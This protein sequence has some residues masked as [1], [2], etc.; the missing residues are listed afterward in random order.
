MRRKSFFPALCLLA[1][2]TAC[3]LLVM[4]QC[5]PATLAAPQPPT[6]QSSAQTSDFSMALDTPGKFCVLAQRADGLW[7]CRTAPLDD[8]AQNMLTAYGITLPATLGTYQL[9]AVHDLELYLGDTLWLDDGV[10]LLS[11]G[12]EAGQIYDWTDRLTVGSFSAD[13][14][15]PA[16]NPEHHKPNCPGLY[17]SFNGLLLLAQLP[18]PPNGYTEEP[19]FDGGELCNQLTGWQVEKMY[20]YP[21]G[22]QSEKGWLFTAPNGWLS[23]QFTRLIEVSDPANINWYHQ[24]LHRD[25]T[26]EELAEEG[27]WLLPLLDVANSMK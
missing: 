27:Q 11:G 23:A 20:A 15:G 5:Y 22:T 13:Y 3:L 17:V 26:R 21:M 9:T 8:S 19:P 1:L 10:M 14:V 18:E 7:Q 6:D 16:E 24:A 2:T 12:F 4:G 25:M